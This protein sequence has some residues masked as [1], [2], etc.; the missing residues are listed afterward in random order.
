MGQRC[1]ILASLMCL[2]AADVSHAG[3]F[4]ASIALTDGKTNRASSSKSPTSAP[5]ARRIVLQGSVD[6][7]FTV[8]WKVVRN[9]NEEA[10][11]VLVHFFVVKLDRQGQAPPALDPAVVILECALTMDFPHDQATRATQQFR[12]DEPGLYLVRIEAGADP[13]KPGIEDFAEIELVVK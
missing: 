1:I 7:S 3:G 10:K 11:D 8:N 6:G 12:V 13:E 9:G 4:G 5:T 2:M